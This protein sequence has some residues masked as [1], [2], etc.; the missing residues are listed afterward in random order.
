[1]HARVLLACNAC[2]NVE[3]IGIVDG[4][5]VAAIRENEPSREFLGVKCPK[6]GSAK[7]YR[8]CRSARGASATNAGDS[9]GTP[10][11]VEAWR[12]A[13]SLCSS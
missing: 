3:S 4:Y 8:R 1:M 11:S 2:C 6:Q 12:E 7:R 5:N 13:M 9:Q 10:R